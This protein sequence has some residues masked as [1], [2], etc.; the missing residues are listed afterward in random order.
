MPRKSSEGVA[1]GLM[2]KK[3]TKKMPCES[4]SAAAG[5]VFY[6]TGDNTGTYFLFGT[7]LSKPQ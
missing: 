4:L 3:K 6:A 7:S 2:N 1:F 5:R